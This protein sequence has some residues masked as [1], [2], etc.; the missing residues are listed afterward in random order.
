MKEEM[1]SIG[2]DLREGFMT[3]NEAKEQLL[4]LF[5]IGGIFSSEKLEQAY[6]DGVRDA[7]TKG[8]GTFNQENYR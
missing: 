4:I 2:S 5:G 8:Y 7:L 6:K 3:A 1:L